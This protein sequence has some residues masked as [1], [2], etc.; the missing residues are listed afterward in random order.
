M[1]ELSV[2]LGRNLK[3]KNPVLLASGTCGYGLEFEN[4]YPLS[5][6]GGICTKGLSYKPIEGNPTPRIVETSCGMI[7]SIGLQNIGA[8]AF[9][10]EKL[11]LLAKKDTKIIVNIFG[12]S[13]EEYIK[14]VE[15]LSEYQE[16]DGF[17]VNIS[18]PNVKKGGI[19]FGTNPKL[20]KTLVSKLRKTTEKHLMIKLSPNVTDITEFAKVCEGEGADSI[21]LI[22]TLLGMAVNIETKKFSI[23]RKMGG[24]S[25]PA[26]K[27]V[28]LRMVYQCVKA[29]KIPVIGI[30]GISNYKDALEFLLIG[31]KAIQIGTA[32]F[33]NP[34]CGKEIVE[35][36]SNFLQNKGIENIN[37][38]IGSIE[39]E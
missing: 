2:D 18:C 32:N 12:Y 28:A 11:P 23:K 24:F 10:E 1:I 29:V 37:Q 19:Q 25:G 6:I 3:L 5:K 34:S 9:V 21:S 17:E 13:L 30:G 33:F 4:F 36:I 14:V 38:W 27:P 15:F 8:K 20:T 31:A 22:N 7:N 16:I 26:I 35:G 39:D